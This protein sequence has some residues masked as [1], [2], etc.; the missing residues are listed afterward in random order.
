MST[1]NDFIQIFQAVKNYADHHLV[2]IKQTLRYLI[3]GVL[4]I[5]YLCIYN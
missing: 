4:L 5:I 1:K 2:Y 3:M